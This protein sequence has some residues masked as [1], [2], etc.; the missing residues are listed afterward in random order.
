[1]DELAASG[2]LKDYRRETLVGHL[3]GFPT[4]TDESFRDA[5]NKRQA[6]MK[7]KAIIRDFSTQPAQKFENAAQH[8]RSKDAPV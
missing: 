7:V 6:P 2:E 3:Y 8:K 5:R 1:M 4:R